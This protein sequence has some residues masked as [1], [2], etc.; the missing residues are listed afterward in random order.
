VSCTCAD[1]EYGMLQEVVLAP[2]IPFPADFDTNCIAA[3]CD[4]PRAVAQHKQLVAALTSRGVYC[5]ILEPDPS[6]PYQCYT[7]DSAVATP[8]GLLVTRMGFAPRREEPARVEAFAEKLG[9]PIWRRVEK[10]TMEGGDV[11]LLRPGVVAI[12]CNGGRTTLDAANQVAAWFREMGWSARVL[13]YAESL[14]HLDQILGVI[15][16]TN[17]I[18]CEGTL[19]DQDVEWLRH[20]GFTIHV[21]PQSSWEDL[22]CNV[23]SLGNG[24]IVTVDRNRVLNQKLAEKGFDV[25]SL[26]LDEYVRDFG[27]PHCLTLPIRR[28]S[29]VGET[30]DLASPKRAKE[31]SKSLSLV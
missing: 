2:P 29:S 20:L 23:V 19:L 27:G 16:A 9:I 17:C 15:D 18:L 31:C 30:A 10:G 12:G 5:H 25:I 4:Y 26:H 28:S 11:Q 3:S 24:S 13:A 21:V 6:L 14:I 22:P 1:S 7:R 8:W